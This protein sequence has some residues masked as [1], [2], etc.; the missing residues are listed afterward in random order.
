MNEVSS[1]SYFTAGCVYQHL[2]ANLD[3]PV[4]EF[5]LTQ[6]D[7]IT[8]ICHVLGVRV[9]LL[10]KRHIFLVPQSALS[11]NGGEDADFDKIILY[12]YKK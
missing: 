9:Y 2:V 12:L 7:N 10:D 8:E 3:K 6:D 1:N 4:V 5:E 11:K